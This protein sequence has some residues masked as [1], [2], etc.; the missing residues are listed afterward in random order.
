LGNFEVVRRT[1]A[2]AWVEVFDES[3]SWVAFD[4]TP[5]AATRPEILSAGLLAA[6][7]D[8]LRMLWEMY[9]VAFDVER[10]RGVLET[11]GALG[12]RARATLAA[13]AARALA[14]GKLI[15]A[16]A[17][18]ALGLALL[19]R[20]SRGLRLRFRLPVWRWRRRR[21]GLG[22]RTPGFYETLVRRLARLGIERRPSETAAEFAAA[23][24]EHLPG[25]TELTEIYYRTR[26][27]GEILGP[28]ESRRATNLASAVCLAALGDGGRTV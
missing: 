11:A 8:S 24:E 1:H 15:A 21:G 26:F 6:G 7:I 5:S 9:V 23:W 19:S 17:L 27:G 18:A 28:A 10:Q 25:M 2:H 12:A 3:A 20:T 22:G 13:L 4:P 14:G 16:V